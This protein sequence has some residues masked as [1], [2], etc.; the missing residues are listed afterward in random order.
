MIN[1]RLS[2][3]QEGVPNVKS[4]SAIV[5]KLNTIDSLAADVPT[6]KAQTS[7]TQQEKSSHKNHNKGKSVWQDEEEDID[8][9][10]L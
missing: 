10:S 9:P 6:L 8:S 1:T 5:S 7:C 3:S 2:N 4:L